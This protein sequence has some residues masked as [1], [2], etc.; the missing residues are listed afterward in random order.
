MDRK[1]LIEGD[2]QSQ[3][4]ALQNEL[5]DIRQKIDQIEHHLN[6]I[7]QQA[8]T[9]TELLRLVGPHAFVGLRY[10]GLIIFMI[11]APWR[12]SKRVLLKIRRV[13]IKLTLSP[14]RVFYLLLFIWVILSQ[15]FP[16]KLLAKVKVGE[17]LLSI[18]STLKNIYTRLFPLAS[19]SNSPHPNS[20]AWANQPVNLSQRNVSDDAVQADVEYAAKI[21][22]LYLDLLFTNQIN[23]KE[24]VV[25][26]VGPGINYGS[27]LLLSCY[28]AK[29]IVA[30]RFLAPWDSQYHPR[31]YACLRDWI[32]EN[33]PQADVSPLESILTHNSYIPESIN[34]FASP[35]EELTGITTA[36]VD[37][38]F[39]N[40]VLEHIYDP[41]VA[42]ISLARV[43]KPG[44]WGFHQV[45]FRDHRSMDKPLEFLLMDAQ[46]FAKE[47]ALRHGECGNRYRPWEYEKLFQ[48]AGFEIIKFEANI[49]A[50]DNYLQQF[51]P[52]LRAY[53]GSP[54]QF[55]DSNDL[56]IVSG[57]YTLRR[58]NPKSV[59]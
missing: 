47:F 17:L 56:K 30:D 8:E 39:S 21:G 6:H 10:M 15:Y 29:V 59:V 26:E 35:M 51:I 3:I 36:S 19:P 31:F 25:L 22:R 14:W 18:A 32:Q 20:L 41:E 54:H 16:F 40:A 45:D 42:F 4:E 23:P 50:E 46:E 34:C 44:G 13:S 5:V 48:K 52:R 1:L 12:L 33:L 7:Q 24:K 55:V 57:H 27:A 53:S 9:T 28:G 49:F 11:L 37:I 38:I 2:K 58:H 43:S